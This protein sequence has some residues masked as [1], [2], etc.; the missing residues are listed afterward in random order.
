MARHFT[1]VRSADRPARQVR[2]RP[3]LPHLGFPKA[4]EDRR[5][6]ALVSIALHVVIIALLVVPMAAG[7]E[8][9]ERAQGA[10]GAGPAGGGGGGR[11]GK[12]GET[13]V[14][15]FIRI[16]APP[17]A[18]ATQAPVQPKVEPP[19]PPVKA[20][21]P[22][23]TPVIQAPATTPNVSAKPLDVATTPGSG[24]GTGHDGTAGNGPGSGGGVGSGIGTGRGSGVGP[25]T[26]GG[27]QSNYPP[28]PIE[29]FIPPMPV[30]GGAQGA[31]VIA[32]FDV[33]EHGR[34]LGVEFTPT[35]DRGYNRRLDE[36]FRSFR[37]RPGTRPDGT[38]IRM[39]Y[40]LVVD[41]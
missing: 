29:L 20:P 24:G 10:G 39:K 13:E 17:A 9:I 31:H 36:V 37:F 5:G 22:I 21:E 15:H 7:H 27:T 4:R 2:Q 30:P 12:G 32:E 3:A 18:A 34:V 26:G 14:L 6:G 11:S 35:R 41:L 40:Q 25:G 16:A 19:K 28:S 33:D 38:P 23:Q 1:S 8:L